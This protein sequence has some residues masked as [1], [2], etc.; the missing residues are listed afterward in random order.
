MLTIPEEI[1]LKM[2]IIVSN[3]ELP[4]V[5]WVENVAVKTTIRFESLEP[6]LVYLKAYISNQKGLK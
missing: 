2:R 5:F 4:T 6:L 1:N 3:S